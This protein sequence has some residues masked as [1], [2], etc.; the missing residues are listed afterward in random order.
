MNFLFWKRKKVVSLRPQFDIFP[1]I[2]WYIYKA[3][4]DKLF[5]EKVVS[6]IETLQLASLFGGMLDKG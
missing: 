1:W 3:R 2:C 4:D 5:N 6:L